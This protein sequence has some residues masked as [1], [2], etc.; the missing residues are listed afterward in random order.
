MTDSALDYDR[1]QRRAKK[2]GK[3]FKRKKAS[4]DIWE[5]IERR[6]G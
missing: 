2:R 6:L 5:F 3:R 1:R 4:D